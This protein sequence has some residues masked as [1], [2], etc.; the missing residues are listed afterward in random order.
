MSKI[1][2]AA[3]D[4]DGTLVPK[5]IPNLDLE[6]DIVALLQKLRA[7]HDLQALPDVEFQTR[8]L[9]GECWLLLLQSIRE[10]SPRR[11][12]SPYSPRDCTHCFFH[13]YYLL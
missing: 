2:L 11:A 12:E 5:D 13:L 10:S 3:F 8:S 1:R 6:T 9:L 4:F 7:L